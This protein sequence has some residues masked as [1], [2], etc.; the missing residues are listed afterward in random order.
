[1]TG[2]I[3]VVAEQWRGR[4][5]PIT[6]EGL[7]LG[8]EVADALGTPLHAVLMGHQA[9]GLA[10]KLGKADAVLYLDHPMLAEPVAGTYAEALWPVAQEREPACI[11]IPLTNVT[12]G[13]GTLLAAKLNAPAANFCRDLRVAGGVVQARCVMY[14]GKM[15]S[16]V[17]A[18]G[19]P[20]VVGL[21]PGS[22]PADQGMAAGAP[23]L[24]E[25]PVE[26]PEMKRVELRRYIEPETGDVDITQQEVLVAVGRGI[27]AKENLEMVERMAELLGGAVCGSRPV[28]DQGWLPLSRQV[29]KSGMTVKPKLYLALGISGAPEHTEGMK[30]STLIVVVNTDPQAPIFQLAHY[31]VV[32]DVLD[33]IPALEEAVGKRKQ[34]SSHA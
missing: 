11:L 24:E 22:R 18:G 9:A 23:S 29:G 31:G 28:I 25:I 12:L 32:A 10:E 20:F 4:I 17:A 21:W 8:R 16:L 15:E 3:W 33:V 6:F 27:Q 7:A 2:A 30:D 14:G 5:S 19:R 1:M 26:L 34:V 13:F